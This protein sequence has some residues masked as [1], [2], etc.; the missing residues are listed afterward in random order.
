MFFSYGDL[1][2]SLSHFQIW[3]GEFASI[4]A[5]V[6]VKAATVVATVGFGVSPVNI[7]TMYHG[8]K[9]QK[10]F[11]NNR[12]CSGVLS[13]PEPSYSSKSPNRRPP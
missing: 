12:S 1:V 7:R 4:S 2:D 10:L 9:L 3:D 13:F 5:V 11:D 8:R 6:F